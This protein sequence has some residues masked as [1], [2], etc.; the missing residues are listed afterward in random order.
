MN[1]SFPLFFISYY[2]INHIFLKTVYEMEKKVYIKN[3]SK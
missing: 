3:R 2:F 1:Y